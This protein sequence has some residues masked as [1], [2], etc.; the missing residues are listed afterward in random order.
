M[1][2]CQRE[3]NHNHQCIFKKKS[4]KLPRDQKEK[5]LKFR[6]D[7]LTRVEEEKYYEKK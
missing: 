1:F 4:D 3:E 7:Y 5:A 6:E 2:F